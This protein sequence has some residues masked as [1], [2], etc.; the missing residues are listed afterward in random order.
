[1]HRLIMLSNTYQM[2]SRFMDSANSRID[3]DNA[4]LWRMNRRRLEGEEIWDAIHAAAGDLNLKM[5]GRPVMPPLSKPEM[6]AL[7]RPEEWV[8]PADPQEANRRGVYVLVRRN[9]SFPLF[10]RFDMPVNAE[11]CPR[12][13]V[14]TVAPQVLW[15][16][17]NQASFQEAQHFASR[18]VREAHDDPSAWIKKAWDIALSR[19][20][21]AQEEQEA[22]ALIQNLAEEGPG[23]QDPKNPMPEELAKLGPS[24]SEALAKLCLAVFN[25]DEF[26]YID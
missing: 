5:Y 21:T 6:I 23:K 20:P 22:L 25:L 3:P 16:L 1:M 9:F 8:T 24:R 18:L 14:T 26:I 13:D 7:R 15:T 11:S 2:T 10:D 19:R 17:N 4:Y 12:R